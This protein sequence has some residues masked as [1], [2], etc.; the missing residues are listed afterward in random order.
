MKS[1]KN[2]ALVIGFFLLFA[3]V[4]TAWKHRSFQESLKP[5]LKIDRYASVVHEIPFELLPGEKMQ[6]FKVFRVFEDGQREMLEYSIYTDR[7]STNENSVIQYSAQG[8]NGAM[9]DH[10]IYGETRAAL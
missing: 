5:I 6:T 9:G 10:P 2:L 4:M 3:T 8:E 1:S 7:D